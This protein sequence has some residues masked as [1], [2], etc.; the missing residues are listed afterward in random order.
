MLFPP[1]EPE[2]QQQDDAAEDVRGDREVKGDPPPV[3]GRPLQAKIFLLTSMPPFDIFET[4]FRDAKRR[5]ANPD[6]TDRDPAR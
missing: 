5:V 6:C 3:P 1:D 4:P 2:D